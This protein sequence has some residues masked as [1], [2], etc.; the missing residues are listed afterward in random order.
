VVGGIAGRP[1]VVSAGIKNGW[2]MGVAFF[3]ERTKCE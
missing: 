1:V 2:L 3:S